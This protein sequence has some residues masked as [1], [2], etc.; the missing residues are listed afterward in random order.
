MSN[1]IKERIL[2]LQEVMER[3]GIGRTCI[4]NWMNEG[5]FPRSI[6]LGAKAVGWLESEID[7][8]IESRVQLSRV[9]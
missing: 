3:T 2:R 7:A 6:H 5:L 1:E 9:A 8:W 4:Y